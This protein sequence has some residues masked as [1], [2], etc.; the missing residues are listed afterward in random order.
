MGGGSHAASAVALVAAVYFIARLG[1]R[2]LILRVA[3]AL[4]CAAPIILTDSKQ[5]LIV[6]MISVLALALTKWR[7]F[8]YALRYLALLGLLLAITVWM[9]ATIFPAIATWTDS[10]K[11]IVGFEQKLTV[12]PLIA[13]F[14]DSPLNLLFGLGPGHT[15]GRLGYVLA[16]LYQYL[17]PLGATTSP[18]TEAVWQ[19]NQAHWIT[20]SVTGSSM[21][22]LLFSWAGIWGDLGLLGLGVYLCL[23][24]WVWRRFSPTDVSRFFLISI[25]VLGAIFGLVGG[26][27]FYA[28]YRFPYRP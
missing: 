2:S 4:V 28:L 23:W 25:L 21:W 7:R 9:A 15:V 14:Y 6:F 19:A 27:A 16:R 20:N 17:G 12:F 26:A 8:G 10:T 24:W 13:S 3:F 18:V 5:L 11:F 1:V 22:S